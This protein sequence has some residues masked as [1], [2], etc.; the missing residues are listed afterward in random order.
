M[1]ESISETKGC[2]VKLK[3]LPLVILCIYNGIFNVC[4]CVGLCGGGAQNRTDERKDK[5]L[6]KKTHT[7]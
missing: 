7:L 6:K 3:L 2:K 1:E 5:H 4:V